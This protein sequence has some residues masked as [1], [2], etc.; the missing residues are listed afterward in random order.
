MKSFEDILS[1]SE[2][3]DMKAQF[4]L[5]R[6]Y[7]EGKHV[8]Q[9]VEKAT[10]W[11]RK[12]AE[13]GFAMA[14]QELGLNYYEGRGVEKSFKE[15][16]KWYKRAA[17]KL[18]PYSMH[19]LALYYEEGKGV[20]Q[21]FKNAFELFLKC[22]E[23][24]MAESQCCVADYYRQGKYVKK[25]TKQAIEWYLKK[26]VNFIAYP[27]GKYTVEAENISKEA[28][29]RAGFMADYGLA[30]KEPQHYV[31]TRIPIYGANSH[32]LFRFKMRLKYS[33][34]FAPIQ[35][36]KERLISD[37]NPEVADLIWTP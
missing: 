31:L 30:H 12:S 18:N 28:G 29:Y 19:N 3:G 32:T 13:Q 23:G 1:M 15:A 22:A 21:S 37:G 8:R 26:P 9:S 2:K 6:C 36:L 17:D 11:F 33:P 27:Q 7:L 5:G 4:S 25:D 16:V 24:G 14:Q 10:Y 34:I 20:K 35:R